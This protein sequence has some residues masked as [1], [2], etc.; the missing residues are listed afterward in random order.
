MPKLTGIFEKFKALDTI[1]VSEI[2][3]SLNIKGDPHS[4]ENFIGNRVLYP[5]TVAISASDLELDHKILFEALK[6]QPEIVFDKEGQNV[7]LTEEYSSRFPP[8]I[9]LVTTI[10]D[11]INPEGLVGLYLRNQQM[12]KLGTIISSK[13]AKSA[14]MEAN[15]KN[16]T[17]Q[18]NG[19]LKNLTKGAINLLP[20]KDKN[21][22]LKIGGSEVAIPGG[23]MGIFLDLRGI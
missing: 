13:L 6:K 18:I 8:F 4:V 1:S 9:K 19:E 20:Y 10:I 12:N 2:V 3:S 7:I 21:L 14:L 23:E 15:T 16:P 5:Q 11:A 22:K 17:I